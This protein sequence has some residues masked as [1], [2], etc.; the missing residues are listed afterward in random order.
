MQ[1]NNEEKVTIFISGMSSVDKNS[2]IRLLYTD[3]EDFDSFPKNPQILYAMGVPVIWM[4]ISFEGKLPSAF[5]E[6]KFLSFK[7]S[8]PEFIEEINKLKKDR[9][10]QST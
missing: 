8:K 9:N 1:E 6:S 7:F 5:D 3:E 4:W 2:I 10:E